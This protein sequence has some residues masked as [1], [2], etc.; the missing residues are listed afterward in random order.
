M[1][2]GDLRAKYDVI[3]IPDQSANALLKGLPGR[4]GNSVEGE[5]GSYPAEFAGGLGELGTDAL[6]QFVEAGGTL[7]TFNKASSFAIE[8]FKLPVRDVIAGLPVREFYCPGSILRTELDQTSQLTFGL[9]RESIAWFEGSPAF[10]VTDSASARVIARYPAG[11]SSLLSGWILGEQR[12]RGK[13]ALVEARMGKGRVVLF[14]FR[15]QY[16]GQSLA[17]VPLI[18]N[19]VLTSTLSQ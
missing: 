4:A 2:A 1:K 13:G 14:G 6:R 15:P 7:V 12:L 11:A 9:D 10:E 18:F 3:I 16:R 5:S 19:A 8:Q 17:T